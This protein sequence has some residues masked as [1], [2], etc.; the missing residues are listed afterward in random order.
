MT[1]NFRS[2]KV[3]SS[4]GRGNG[5]SGGIEGNQGDQGDQGDQMIGRDWG[6]QGIRVSGG[7]GE[8]VKTFQ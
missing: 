7:L 6:D 2:G 8:Q 3:E 1:C 5:G 4:L